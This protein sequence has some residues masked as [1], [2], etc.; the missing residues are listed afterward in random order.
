[1]ITL[2]EEWN[3]DG[4]LNPEY[5]VLFFFKRIVQCTHGLLAQ[6]R[7]SFLFNT[8]VLSSNL[9]S[10]LTPERTTDYTCKKSILSSIFVTA[11]SSSF[12]SSSI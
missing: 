9:S 8:V 4:G 7:Y 5:T 6:R 1:M 2:T 12:F 3:F 10:N 11:V